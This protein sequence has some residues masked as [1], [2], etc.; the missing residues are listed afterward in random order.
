[1]P[2]VFKN[3][4]D[5]MCQNLWNQSS[6][7]LNFTNISMGRRVKNKKNQIRVIN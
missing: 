5:K 6:L 3:F 7:F 4:R 1:M 2:Y